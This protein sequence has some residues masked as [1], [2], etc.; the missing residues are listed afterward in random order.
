MTTSPTP[1]RIR[2]IEQLEELLSRPTPAVV[3]VLTQL[4]GDILILGVGGKMGPT[5]ARMARRATD[6]AGTKRRVIGV[7]RFSDASLPARLASHGVETIRGDLLDEQF[8]KS[9]PDAPNVVFMAGMKFGAADDPPLTW[10]MNTYV[11]T[12]V[13]RQFAASRIVAFSTGNVY[14]LVDAASLGSVETDV[15]DPIGEYAMSCL[16]RERMFEYFSRRHGTPLSIIRLNYACELRYGVLVDVAQRVLAEQAVDVSMG[17]VSVIWQADANAMTL[18]TLAD[19]TPG[20]F[21]VNITGP[22]KLFIREVAES[23]GK[24]M[25]K[26]VQ[27]VGEEQPRAFLSDASQAMEKYGPPRICSQQMI[28]WIANWVAEGKATL[29]KPTRFEVADGSF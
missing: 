18:Q 28:D 11:P 8:V 23:F 14:G 21:V 29:G 10:A 16:G 4:D 17:C 5:L 25:G 2:D 19:A 3:E 1:R 6:E 27:I 22:E 7:S 15:P 20:G 24:H 12:L 9:L 13:G 26:K